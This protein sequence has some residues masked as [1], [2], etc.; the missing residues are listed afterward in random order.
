MPGAAAR[1]V[2]GCEALSVELSVLSLAR[3]VLVPEIKEV[4]SHKYK[5]PMVSV[6][7]R[8]RPLRQDSPGPSQ[9]TGV[10]EEGSEAHWRCMTPTA[11]AEASLH[12]WAIIPPDR[13]SPPWG[14]RFPS[15][16][17]PGCPPALSLTLGP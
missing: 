14:W 8:D 15:E 9:G 13:L 17:Y 7:R 3:P 16:K 4:V 10:G 1:G 6:P 2:P 5:T 11:D 12:P